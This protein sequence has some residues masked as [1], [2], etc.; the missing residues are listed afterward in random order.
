MIHMKHCERDR[1]GYFNRVKH[2]V[3]SSFVSHESGVN[4]L[5]ADVLLV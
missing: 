2:V 5:C 3:K 1:R 4:Q